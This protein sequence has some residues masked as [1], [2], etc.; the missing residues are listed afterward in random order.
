MPTA[1]ISTSEMAISIVA[2]AA[3]VRLMLSLMPANIWRGSVRCPG[4]AI[5]SATT[6]SSNEV[7]NAKTAPESDAGQDQRQHDPAE[8]RDRRGAEALRGAD[9]RAVETGQRREDGDDD[10]RHAERRVRED[11]PGVAVGQSERREAK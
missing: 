1:I 9:Q 2:A 5:S 11:Q 8:R 7:A 10:E 3:I 4:P 6:T